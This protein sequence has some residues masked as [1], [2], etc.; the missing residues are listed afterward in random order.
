MLSG[1]MSAGVPGQSE[2]GAHGT[3]PVMYHPVGHRSTGDNGRNP[4]SLGCGTG[5][6]DTAYRNPNA[7]GRPHPKIGRKGDDLNWARAVG[8]VPGTRIGRS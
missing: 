3:A 5:D 4:C 1:G 6:A 7:S 2:G 8:A